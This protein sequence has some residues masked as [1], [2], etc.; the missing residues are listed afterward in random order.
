MI[1]AIREF[2]QS[3]ATLLLGLAVGSAWITA[4]VAPNTSYDRLT[5]AQADGHVR[6]LLKAASD[7]IAVLLLCAGALAIL[8]G[9]VIAGI[10]ALIAAFG[11]FTNR[12]TLAN[13]KARA[14]KSD[15]KQAGKTR[16]VI[17][18]SMTLIFTLLAAF[19]GVLAVFGL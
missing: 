8:G 6:E 13:A 2:G 5:D 18:V 10:S 3:G 9:A 15:D 19:A 14:A 12:W 11:F 1:D 17:A 7:P 16:R 4:I